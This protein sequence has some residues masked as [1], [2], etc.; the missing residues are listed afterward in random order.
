MPGLTSFLTATVVKGVGP[1]S[2]EK[3]MMADMSRKLIISVSEPIARVVGPIPMQ[4]SRMQIVPFI[5]VIQKCN[6]I[7]RE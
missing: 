4:N 3:I 1:C 2:H 5:L 7:T 6:T